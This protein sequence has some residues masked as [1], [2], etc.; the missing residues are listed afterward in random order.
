MYEGVLSQGYPEK[1]WTLV[2]CLYFVLLVVL[3]NCIQREHLK[4]LVIIRHTNEIV[5]VTMGCPMK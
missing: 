2:W 4:L 1:S 5:I 3:G